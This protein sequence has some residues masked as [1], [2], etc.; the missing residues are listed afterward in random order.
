MYKYILAGI[1]SASIFN[2]ALAADEIHVVD[3][4]GDAE[5]YFA[6]E[7]SPNTYIASGITA[8]PTKRPTIKVYTPDSGIRASNQEV[9]FAPVAVMT[10]ITQP[11]PTTVTIGEYQ[12]LVDTG[13]NYNAS[14]DTYSPNIQFQKQLGQ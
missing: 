9:T 1:I 2:S 8:E 12:R 11:I 4:N 10:P 3:D 7:G 5:I 13:G 6:K 14:G